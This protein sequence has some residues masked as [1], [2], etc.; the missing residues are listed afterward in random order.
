MQSLWFLQ[1]KLML[2]TAGGLSPD[3]GPDRA[4]VRY[5]YLRVCAKPRAEVARKILVNH[6]IHI[7]SAA[8]GYFKT[9]GS[10]IYTT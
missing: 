9:Y 3:A 6:D 5:E 2:R 8:I 4:V 10:K 1:M 7:D